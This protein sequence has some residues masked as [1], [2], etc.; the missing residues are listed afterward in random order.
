MA[1]QPSPGATGRLVPVLVILQCLPLPM[2]ALCGALA[3]SLERINNALSTLAQARVLLRLSVAHPAGDVCHRALRGHRDDL[4]Q[5]SGDSRISPQSVCVLVRCR[6]THDRADLVSHQQCA[7]ALGRTSPIDDVHCH[8][9]FLLKRRTGERERGSELCFL[10]FSHSPV[11]LLGVA[12]TAPF[13]R[14]RA[15]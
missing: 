5:H 9:A 2:V 3:F 15:D 4:V 12:V 6:H 1:Q 14:A 11:L 10:P 8:A 7:A 13:S